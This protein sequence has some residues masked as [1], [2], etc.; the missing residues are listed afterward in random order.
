MDQEQLTLIADYIMPE[1]GIGRADIALLFG[2]RHGIDHFC[3]RTIALWK[4]DYFSRL[5][6]SGGKTAGLPDSEASIIADKLIRTGM[7]ADIILLE[8]N[9][10]NTGENVIFS[11]KLIDESF[12]SQ[13]INSILA[14]GKIS[15]SRRYLM[16]LERHWPGPQKFFCPINYF[17]VER[18]MWHTHPEFKKR[19]MTEYEKIPGYIKAGFLTEI[20]D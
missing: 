7:P 4:S 2:T 3:D 5:V 12:G 16:T 10:T 15:S 8:E 20:S 18:L 17:G 11:K 14:I 13:K 6:V 19:V 9:S 1:S